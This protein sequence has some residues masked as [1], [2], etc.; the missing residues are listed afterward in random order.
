MKLET[1]IT[2]T[3]VTLE[4]ILE[5]RS[6]RADRQK[7][8]LKSGGTCLISFSLNIAGEIKQFPLACAAFNEGLSE[9]RK[10]LADRQVL[11]VESTQAPTGSQA[12][13]LLNAEVKKTKNDMAALEE[14]HP[15]GRLFDI[16]VLGID[17]IPVSRSEFGLPPRTCLI[18]GG[19]AKACARSRA[20]SIELILWRTAQ[21]LNDYFRN[22]TA[23]QA[24]SCSVRA[25]LY[26]VSSTPKPGL[27]DRD[28]S[29]SHRDM[30]FFT[31][32]DS[33]AALIPWFR[34]FFCI[35]WDHGREPAM[36]LFSRLRF[37]GKEAEG[38]MFAATG[39]INTH[40]GLVFAFAVLCAALGK[41]HAELYFRGMEPAADHIEGSGSDKFSP[42][43]VPPLDAVLAVC[44]ELGACSLEDFSVSRFPDGELACSGDSSPSGKPALSGDSSPD[45]K[46]A[47]SGD[48]SPDGKPALSGAPP[49]TA[50]EC[51]HASYGIRGARG[52]A[53]DGFPSAVNLGLP[54]LKHWIEEGFCLNDAAV[55]TLLS[56]LSSVDDTNMIHRGGRKLALSCK[57]GAGRL[58]SEITKDNYKE[59]LKA[60]DTFYIR[61]NLS[62]GGCADLLAVS[63]MLYFLE[64]GG[65]LHP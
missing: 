17:G 28:N 63:L 45:G 26:E 49:Q 52:E 43:P 33:S 8:L 58:L 19:N 35:G 31:F 36:L 57:K 29:G 24:A 5:A 1:I 56:L 59:K 41:T 61:E 15:L 65:L 27:V 13:F 54:A 60:L 34:D 2:G 47:C 30:D 51:C 37:A 9:I 39:G 14:S 25:L 38:R 4:E 62:P 10:R 3:P 20:H 7:E 16:D 22:K 23:D 42:A 55:M 53:A 46:L 12:F 6:R 21:L 18:C 48:S 44:R 64:T 11:A 50:G 40:K 32:L